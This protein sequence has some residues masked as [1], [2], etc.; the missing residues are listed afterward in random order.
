MRTGS[1][2]SLIATAWL[3]SVQAFSN[4][5][6]VW[7]PVKSDSRITRIHISGVPLNYTATIDYHCLKATCST[8]QSLMDDGTP[9]PS[10]FSVQ[11][12][13]VGP[14]PVLV[15][16]WQRGT[17]CN[18]AT[19]DEYPLVFWGAPVA[20]PSSNTHLVPVGQPVC[21]VHPPPAKSR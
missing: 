11:L 8:L 7:I 20:G 4:P 1:I 17:P 3:V 14:T 5:V 12:E 10:T 13:G 16:R 9:R 6:G 21:F 2:A 18:R 19:S 15:L